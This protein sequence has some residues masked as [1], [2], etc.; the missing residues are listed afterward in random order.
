MKSNNPIGVTGIGG[1]F[2]KCRNIEKT[3]EWYSKNLN[4]VTNEYGSLFEFKLSENI[5]K[6]GYLQWSPFSDKTTYFEPSEK[7]FMI[8]YRV[9]NLDRLSKN[10]KNNGVTI[11]D[12]IEVYEYGKFLHILDC[13]NN[14]IELWEPIDKV[15]T[16][17]Y[18]G[19]TT[20]KTGIGGV[21]FK[22]KNPEKLKLW[23]QDNLG[24][25][26]NEYGSLFCFHNSLKPDEK[27][28]L[29]WSPMSDSTD[30]FSPS[31]QEYMINYRV[32]NL[33][34]LVGNLKR[35]KVEILDSI[36]YTDYG[37]FIHILGPEGIKIEL[38]EPK[39]E[40]Q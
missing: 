34:L 35:N 28:F 33:P 24:I 16:D 2:F 12:T 3:K 26:T 22:S 25:V 40:T 30:Y 15:F 27:N 31:R 11:L 23:Y 14:K 18:T 17:L 4:L 1:I 10:L 38:W 7:D 32:N 36:E 19:S 13:E 29:Q 9:G 20:I 37:N 8:N 39:T 21:F 6:S 5:Q